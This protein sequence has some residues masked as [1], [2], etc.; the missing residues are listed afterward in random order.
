[1]NR[2]HFLHVA[3]F[4]GLAVMAP[5]FGR[6]ARASSKFDGPFWI[7]INAQ[8]GWDPTTFCDPKGG[9]IDD[10]YTADQIKT[11]GA[12]SY[13]PLKYTTDNDK[14]TIFDSDAFWQKN[15][16]RMRVFNGVDTQ[17]NN[18]D[19][20]SRTTWSGQLSEGYPAF[21]ALAA[22]VAAGQAEIP[23]AFISNGGYD[24]TQGVVSLT[25][26]GDPST[27]AKVA[28]PDIVDPTNAMSDKYLSDGTAA[29]VFAAQN[30]RLQ[31]LRAK[32]RLPI[33]RQAM[34]SLYLAR[35]GDD[36]L[37][38]LANEFQTYQFEDVPNLPGL[39]NI[40]NTGAA[41]DLSGLM[42]QA[43]VAMLAF[44]AGVAVSANLE[45]GGFDT[46]SDH[47][48]NHLPQVA[49]LLRA[50]EYVLDK[51]KA[52]GL[53]DRTYVVAG[54]DFGRTPQYNMGN[55]KD[56]WNITSF[57]AAGPG[58]GGDRVVGS[59]DANFTAIGVGSDLSPNPTGTVIGTN[60]IHMQLRKLAKIDQSDLANQ[61]PISADDLPL[62]TG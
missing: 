43:Q 50:F 45:I 15:H 1:M 36:G 32:T 44:K 37:G 30:G 22:G 49:Q 16:S 57:L 7:I 3:G 26:V 47:D 33:Q 4:A 34:N 46:H 52:M 19:A 53:A 13:A 11:A 8:G 25:R 28:H 40:Q 59:T 42:Q 21:A 51:L 41:R 54:S 39:A 6:T 38:I 14:T 12:V 61:F 5:A 60:H 20:G 9:T 31:A 27:L 58:I 35:Q 17:T 48:N 62:F 29:R 24:A 18:H 10:W 55:G 56:H 23:L 2:R